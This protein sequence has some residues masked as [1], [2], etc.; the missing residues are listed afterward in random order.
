MNPR[1]DN[2]PEEFTPQPLHPRL[3]TL[4]PSR[5][6]RQIRPGDLICGECGQGNSPTRK[7]CRRCGSSLDEAAAAARLSWRRRVLHRGL[8][9]VPI[10]RRR[11]AGTEEASPE[12]PA[13]AVLRVLRNVLGI[14]VLVAT[15]AYALIPLVRFD[16]DSEIS[17]I[18]NSVAKR[19]ANSYTT[20]HPDQASSNTARPGHPASAAVDG[21][22]DTYWAAPWTPLIGTSGAD[23][24]TLTVHFQKAV[25]IR[26]LIVLSGA[27]NDYLAVNRPSALHLV[28]S[29]HA[30]DTI[31]LQDTQKP[32]T[33]PVKGAVAVTSMQIQIVSSFQSPAND[34]VAISEIEFFALSL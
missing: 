22:T 17:R 12:P 4:A 15:L 5:A 9:S 34:T 29:N 18:R 10:D 31:T 16:V 27:S 3:V 26:R 11:G 13:K 8:K 25:T 24:P 21:F 19:I 32:Q 1:T 6:G 14:L 23:Y 30:G 33:L 2:E 7:F 28:Y 20:V